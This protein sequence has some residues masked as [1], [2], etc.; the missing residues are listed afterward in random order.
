MKK[1]FILALMIGLFCPIITFAEQKLVVENIDENA[2]IAPVW[3]DYVP[4]KYQEPREFPNK[5]KNIAEMTVGVVLTDLIITSPIGIPMI[6]HSATKMKNH[7]WYNR[8]IRFEQG[9]AQAEKIQNP[10][11]KQQFY[12][13]LLKDCG[14]VKQNN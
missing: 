8:K 6:C 5:G 3:E 10:I 12:N 4:K 9:L 11:E 1:I 2:V 14:M 7:T 13:N